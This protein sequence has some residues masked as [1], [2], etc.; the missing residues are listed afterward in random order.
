MPEKA[1]SERILSAAAYFFSLPGIIAAFFLGRKSPFC[2]HHV[3]RALELF[4]FMAG[5]FVSWLVVMYL[6]LFIP[7]AGFP[8]AIALFGIVAAGIL[9]ALVLGVLGIIKALRGETAA[10]PFISPLMGRVEPV[11]GLLGL[12]DTGL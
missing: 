10:F 2:L 4:L 12:H 3:R 8:I 7:Y 5:L 11:F 6:L 9:F 1:L